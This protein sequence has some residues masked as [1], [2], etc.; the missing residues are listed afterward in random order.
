MMAVRDGV[1]A[2]GALATMRRGDPRPWLIAG[3]VSDA[4]D[5]AAF[6]GALRNGRLKGAVPALAVP[7]A[8]VAAA[9]GLVTALRLRR[10]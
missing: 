9:A 3:A 7:G 2:A 6:A 10:R 5:A 4:V 8:A 1:I